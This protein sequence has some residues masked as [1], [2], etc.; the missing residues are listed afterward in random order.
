MSCSE[1]GVEA[2]PSVVREI[3]TGNFWCRFSGCDCDDCLWE[4]ERALEI[5]DG[6]VKGGDVLIADVRSRLPLSPLFGP[7]ADGEFE[8]LS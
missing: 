3:P 2:P 1:D 4:L 7:E 6:A 5:P 8:S